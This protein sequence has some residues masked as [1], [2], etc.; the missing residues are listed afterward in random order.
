MKS[1]HTALLVLVLALFA[2]TGAVAQNATLDK[3]RDELIQESTELMKI[4][5]A[6]LQKSE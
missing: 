2:A 4:F 3:E 1:L 6:I 5:G